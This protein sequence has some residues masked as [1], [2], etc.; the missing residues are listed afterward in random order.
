MLEST[1]QKKLIRKYEAEGFYVLKLIRCNKNGMPDLMLIKDGKVTF[2]EVKQPGK[3]P[4]PLQ[5][6]R[7][8][9]LQKH[10]CTAIVED[11]DESNRDSNR[12]A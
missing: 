11:G 6:I 1:I 12:I 8:Y 7:M 4:T 2:I 10:G 5:R 9:E 3:L